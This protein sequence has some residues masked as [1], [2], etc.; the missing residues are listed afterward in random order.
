M[1]EDLYRVD[2]MLSHLRLSGRSAGMAG[3]MVGR[4]TEM[5]RPTSDGALGFDEVLDTYFA[6]LGIPVAYGFPSAT[7]TT[8]GPC[9]SA[10]APGSTPTPVKSS[11]WKPL[12]RRGH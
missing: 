7:S 6:P 4:F 12:S 11:F 5:E 8:S 9:P 2:R 10:S 1:G 3:V